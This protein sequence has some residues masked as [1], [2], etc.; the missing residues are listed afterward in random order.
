MQKPPFADY[1]TGHTAASLSRISR[2]R[3]RKLLGVRLLIMRQNAHHFWSKWTHNTNHRTAL[4][5]WLPVVVFFTL[6]ATAT[7][8]FAQAD[9]TNPTTNPNDPAYQAGEQYGLQLINVQAAWQYTHGD[10]RVVVAL[11]D[12]GVDY[13]HPELAD[14]IHPDGRTFFLTGRPQ[15]ESGHGT[16]TAGIIA[17]AANDGAG[18]V[19]IASNVQ[20]LPIKVSPGNSARQ[21]T[22]ADAQE[23][24]NY[25]FQD[26]IRYA[27][28]PDRHGTRVININFASSLDDAQERQAIAEVNQ[29]GVLVVASAGNSGQNRALYPAAYDCVLGV[30]AVDRNAQ[31]ASFSTYGLGVDVVAPGVS[32][33]GTDLVGAKGYSQDDY[34]AASGTSFAAPHAS[35]VAALIFSIRPDLS[36]NDVREIIMRSARDV[37]TPGF[38]AEYGYGLID[39]G[40]ALALAQTWQANSAPALEHCTGERYRVYGSLYADQNQNGKR[41]ADEPGVAEPYTN[42]TTFIELYAQNGARRLAVT[43]PNHAG[44]FT[45]DVVY[46][47]K[48]APYTIKLQ[49]ATQQQQLF[50]ADGMAG[51]YDID[52]NSLPTQ[53][54]VISG[55]LFVDMNNDGQVTAGETLTTL[56]G[57]I[58]ATIALYAPNRQDAIAVATNDA[59]GNFRFYLTPPTTTVT[60]EVRTNIAG[61]TNAAAHLSTVTVAPGTPLLAYAIGL[62][63]SALVINGQDQ[64]VN[65]TPVALTVITHTGS[66]VLNWSTPQPL[67][68]DSRFEIAYAQQP[69]GPYQALGL[70]AAAQTT[71]YTIFEQAGLSTGGTLYF[72]VRARTTD[73][74]NSA[75]W[76]GY[77]NEV[78]IATPAITQVFLP[79][80]SR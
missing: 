61:V 54:T 78:S 28:S 18:T 42:T 23:A 49:N 63:S 70:T 60:Y 8:V 44:I 35:G 46:D 25:N 5:Y 10:P 77:S 26:P 52:V 37:G 7:P 53:S 33:Y 15:D 11:I 38:D 9:V 57:Q 51:P 22:T 31:R 40:A 55:S 12:T 56:G 4:R 3:I 58:K 16:L 66:I 29:Q 65:P 64:T 43:Y 34:G 20:I 30:G 24:V 68:S 6:C 13:T 80:I 2:S 19:G 69:G 36:A 41:D 73:A 62:D 45:F 47:A 79:T 59:A 67:R 76:S 1:N 72:V 32:I 75:F 39:A 71:S 17:A 14:H 48:D 27:A 21:L 50:F 74:A